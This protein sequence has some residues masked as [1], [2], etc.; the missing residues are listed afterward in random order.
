MQV[1][2][3]VLT[4]QEEQAAGSFCEI[5]HPRYRRVCH[6][7]PMGNCLWPRAPTLPLEQITVC[8]RPLP[9]APRV[10]E[11]SVSVGRCA[12]KRVWVNTRDS[13]SHVSGGLFALP[14]LTS[15]LL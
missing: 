9:S 8:V 6:V 11:A 15:I 7:I 12:G 14:E 1:L 3:G 13:L 10:A 5:S 4:P 2:H